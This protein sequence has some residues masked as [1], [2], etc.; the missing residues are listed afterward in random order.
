MTA[1]VHH[2]ISGSCSSGCDVITGNL[3]LSSADN[4][5]QEE[6]GFRLGLALTGINRKQCGSMF[7]RWPAVWCPDTTQLALQRGCPSCSKQLM[8]FFFFCVHSY[9]SGVHQ[10]DGDFYVCDRFSN[11]TIEVVIIPFRGWCMLGVFLLL[12]FTCPGYECQDFSGCVM[13][14]MCAQTRPRFILS[15]ERVLGECG[16]KQCLLQGENSFYRRLKRRSKPRS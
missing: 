6:F 7:L 10:F 3:H 13:E 8:V 4:R 5:R 9:I 12:A 11:P 14:C 15:S 2:T 1:L 16:Q